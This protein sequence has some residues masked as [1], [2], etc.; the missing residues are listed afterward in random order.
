[1][2]VAFE[3]VGTERK[4]EILIEEAEQ[5]LEWL[6]ADST[7]EQI[8]Q[9]DEMLRKGKFLWECGEAT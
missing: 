5:L 2:K 1:L 8:Q 7:C 4:P 3:I 9:R 6:K